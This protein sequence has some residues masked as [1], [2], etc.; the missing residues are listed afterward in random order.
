MS[1]ALTEL[2]RAIINRYQGD[3]PVCESPYAQMASELGID[4]AQLIERLQQLLDTGVLTRFGPLFNIEKLGGAFCLAAM[5]VPEQQF[6]EIAQQVNQLEA[7]AHNY[8][9]THALNMWFVIATETPQ[10]IEEVAKHIEQMSGYPVYLF[11][12]QHEFFVELKLTA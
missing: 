11:P 7:I 1:L 3:V 9:R 2:D 12:K 8:Q 10:Q 5:Q 4:E 6:D